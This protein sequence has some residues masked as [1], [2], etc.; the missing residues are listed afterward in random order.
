MWKEREIGIS[1]TGGKEK[2]AIAAGIVLFSPHFFR[3]ESATFEHSWVVHLS[4]QDG[5]PYISLPSH[6]KRCR[7]LQLFIE[8]YASIETVKNMKQGYLGNKKDL[9]Q[10]EE[11]NF[12]M[13][14]VLQGKTICS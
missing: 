5:L 1:R 10:T 2:S 7:F 4:N 6:K 9:T 3:P 13:Y 11:G 14:L 12:V 8:S